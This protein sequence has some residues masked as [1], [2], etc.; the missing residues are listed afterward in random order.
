MLGLIKTFGKGI[1]YVITFPLVLIVLAFY[2]I[3]GLFAFLFLSIKSVI[4]FFQGKTIYSEL[5][6]DKKANE[7][8]LAANN[9]SA[10]KEETPVVEII[11]ANPNPIYMYDDNPAVNP[12]PRNEIPHN[13][14]PPVINNNPAFIPVEEPPQIDKPT[15][16]PEEEP[17]PVEEEIK[18][19]EVKEDPLPTH[20][21]NSNRIFEDIDIE[22]EEESNGLYFDDD[23]EDR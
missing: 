10:P 23:K 16:I 19:V 9:M 18:I 13:D 20:N 21:N 14:I 4:L 3:C 5:E 6:E 7:I 11:N 17:T 8:L 22:D 12:A 2:G 15:F 1:L